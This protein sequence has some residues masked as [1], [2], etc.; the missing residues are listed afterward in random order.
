MRALDKPAG[1]H[2]LLTSGV[3]RHREIARL[4]D[5]ITG[6]EVSRRF[7]SEPVVRRVAK[8]NDVFGGRLST[9]PASSSL[10]WILR[11]AEAVDTSRTRAALGIEFRP[12][13]E[14]LA[15]SI[16]WWAEHDLVN[17]ELAGKLAPTPV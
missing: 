16:R 14:T 17:R 12:I 7:L 15:D 5:E 9:L 3:V 4:L 2:Y 8:L 11:N 10:D 13:R 1:S 6:R